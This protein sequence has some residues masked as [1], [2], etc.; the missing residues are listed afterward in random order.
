MHTL[1]L[2]HESLITH[3]CVCG[4]FTHTVPHTGERWVQRD[5]DET[6]ANFR[7][8]RERES[9][10]RE[11]EGRGKEREGIFETWRV[12]EPFLSLRNDEWIKNNA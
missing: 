3:P 10:G 7:G 9:H 1:N 5:T 8:G 2:L 11:R 4:W 6:V 12:I